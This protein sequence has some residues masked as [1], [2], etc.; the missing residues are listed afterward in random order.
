M[1][2]GYGT[3]GGRVERSGH[4]TL[5]GVLDDSAGPGD[6][7]RYESAVT[8]LVGTLADLSQ[9]PQR[10]PPANTTAVEATVTGMSRGP[11]HARSAIT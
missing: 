11:H 2:S 1:G 10:R 3:Y 5:H 9:Y 6:D 4:V 7:P 8:R